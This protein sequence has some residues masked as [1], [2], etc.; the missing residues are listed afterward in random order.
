MW[1]AYK[2][3]IKSLR[4][5]LNAGVDVDAIDEVLAYRCMYL[6]FSIVS[7]LKYYNVL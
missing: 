6:V 7:R 4:L 2:G 3:R 5:L 1:A